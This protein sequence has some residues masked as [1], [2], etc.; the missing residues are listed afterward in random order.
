MNRY[1]SGIKRAMA[2]RAWS[3]R[4][5]GLPEVPDPLATGAAGAYDRLALRWLASLQQRGLSP[6]TIQT[7]RGT[8]VRYRAWLLS[9]HSGSFRQIAT[10]LAHARVEQFL[11][12]GSEGPPQRGRA[13]PSSCGVLFRFSRWLAEQG[14]STEDLLRRVARPKRHTRSLP[15][16]LT[17]SQTVRLLALPNTDDPLGIRDRSILETFYSTGLRRSE[18]CAIVLS[19]LD[20]ETHQILVRCG[21]G[22]RQ[23]IVPAGKR[24][25]D[26]ISRY[27][28]TTRPT[29]AASDAPDAPLYVTGYGGGFS[30]ASLGHL[31]R[32]YLDLA[33]VTFR[34]SCHILRHS[35]ATDVHDRGGDLAALQKML[36]HSRLDTTA[37]YTHVSTAQLRS[38]HARFHPHGDLAQADATPDL[39]PDPSSPQPWQPGQS[40]AG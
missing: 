3:G 40:A 19:D 13:S 14:H 28:A 30:P 5:G 11:A 4:R 1:I 24:A 7:Y 35:F 16:M 38:I 27:L 39:E 17:R 22:G 8:L 12:L 33:H 9:R 6:T 26:W 15:R 2:M 21:K 23:R 37:I 32:R 36:G 29:L 31:V 10:L 20:F 25:F 34:G 18:L